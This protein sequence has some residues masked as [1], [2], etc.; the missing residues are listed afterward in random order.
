MSI[1]CGGT[2]YAQNGHTEQAT[3]KS[4]LTYKEF[5]SKMVVNNLSYAAEKYNINIA[6]AEVQAAK[7]FPDP[8]LSF[9]WAD[10]QQKR[11]QMGYGFE[12]ELSWDLELGGKRRARKNL[13]H[14][15]KVLAELELQEFFHT[16]RSTK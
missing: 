15:Q 11:M 14:D 16:L 1:V 3:N 5:I 13:A 4:T 7:A 6:E 9:G 8:E 12:A 10:N 2:M